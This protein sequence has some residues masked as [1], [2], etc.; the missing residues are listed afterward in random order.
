MNGTVT[1]RNKSESQSWIPGNNTEFPVRYQ[2]RTGPDLEQPPIQ[3]PR[4]GISAARQ[5]AGV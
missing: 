2:V 3:W 4:S 5:R 1:T